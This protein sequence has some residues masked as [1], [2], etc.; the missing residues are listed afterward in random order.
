MSTLALDDIAPTFQ[1]L[2]EYERAR[3]EANR[4]MAE[5]KI[6]RVDYRG[7]PN[8][9]QRFLQHIEREYTT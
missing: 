6:V 4:R 5:L 2:P 3:I 8:G 9:L 1:P 7:A